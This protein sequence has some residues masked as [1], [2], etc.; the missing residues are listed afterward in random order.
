MDFFKREPY[1]NKKILQSAKGQQCTLRLDG[2]RREPSTVVWAHSPYMEDG[3]GKS[4]KSDDHTG[5]YACQN[6]HDIL[7]GRLQSHYHYG[8]LRDRFHVA[9]KK[10]IRLL[11]DAKI[12][13]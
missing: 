12:L 11:L 9:M 4:Q 1:R 10:S 7:D 6:C 5:C 8:D 2:C 13:S 3:K